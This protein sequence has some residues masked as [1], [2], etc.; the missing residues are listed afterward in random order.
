MESVY[1]ETIKWPHPTIRAKTICAVRD[2]KL[3]KDR[4]EVKLMSFKF[5]LEA[6]KRAPKLSAKSSQILHDS[7]VEDV[8]LQDNSIGSSSRSTDR[9][10]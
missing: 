10:N 5:D 4:Q 9:I 1:S 6:I 2:N 7:Y 3:L 8:K